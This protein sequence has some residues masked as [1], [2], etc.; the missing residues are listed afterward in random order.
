MKKGDL[1]MGKIGIDEMT[2]EEFFAM[3]DKKEK[4]DFFDSLLSAS[5]SSVKQMGFSV[6]SMKKKNSSNTATPKEDTSKHSIGKQSIFRKSDHATGE[7]DDDKW[8]QFL[9]ALDDRESSPIDNVTDHEIHEFG[10]RALEMLGSDSSQEEDAEHRYDKMFKKEIAMYAE[11]LK[12][13]NSQTRIVATKLKSLS[14][15]KGQYGVSKY[16]SD[17][18]EQF[19]ALTKTKVDTVKNMADLKSKAEDFKLKHI[20][21]L[22]DDGQL[23]TDELVDQYYNS[24]MNGGR[25][26]FMSRSLLSQ[27]PYESDREKYDQIINGTYD[28]PNSDMPTRADWNITQPIP[29]ELTKDTGV[30]GD[31]YGYIANESRKPEICIQRFADDRLSFIALDEEG[32][33]VEGCELPGNDLLESMVIKPMSNFAYDKFGRKY[34]I[35]D[36]DTG[37][38]DLG[39]LDDEDY[40][41]DK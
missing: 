19:N 11:I 7:F 3:R 28:N 9:D 31:P 25:A 10:K 18:L 13:V 20:K 22:G 4:E 34:T 5:E 14:N 38:V 37:G 24:I 35:I 30:V 29:D 1:I 12:D 33:E 6:K 8:N 26:E 17:M 32:L 21:S 16:Y 41:L 2:D 23:G 15:G 27:S 39:D 36:V 40:V